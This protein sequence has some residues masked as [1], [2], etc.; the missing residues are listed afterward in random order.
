LAGAA[1]L[2]TLRAAETAL[3]A[4]D[5]V[6]LRA[7]ARAFL[8]PFELRRRPQLLAGTVVAGTDRL[9][10]AHRAKPGIAESAVLQQRR[11]P[12]LQK[13]RLGARRQGLSGPA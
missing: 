6:V 8:W 5:L 3:P 11:S 12:R 9:K 13:R 1:F 10:Q 7:M 2:I 4:A